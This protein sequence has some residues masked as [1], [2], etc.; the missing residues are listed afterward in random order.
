MFFRTKRQLEDNGTGNG[1]MLD[2]YYDITQAYVKQSEHSIGNGINHQV[3]TGKPGLPKKE[4]THLDYPSTSDFKTI[5]KGDKK[6]P[7]MEISQSKK[8]LV[9]KRQVI[10][11]KRGCFR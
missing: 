10:D 11:P 2:K 9:F 1:G 3:M 4:G 7:L 8:E 6:R 5:R